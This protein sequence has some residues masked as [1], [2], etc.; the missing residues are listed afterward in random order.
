MRQATGGT[1]KRPRT[2]PPPIRKKG[3]RPPIRKKA[4]RPRRRADAGAAFCAAVAAALKRG[5]PESIADAMLQ[6]VLTA[7]VKAYAAKAETAESE[8]PFFAPNAVTATE[9]VVAACAMIRAADLNPFD[10]A[11]W[12]RRPVAT[13]ADPWGK[14]R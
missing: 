3:A 7:A 4:A 13:P 11:M 14:I 10:L 12:F 2:I 1:K 8:L 9:T 5:A 6:R